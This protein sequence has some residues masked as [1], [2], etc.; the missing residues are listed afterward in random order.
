MMMRSRTVALDRRHPLLEAGMA[1]L[2]A[3]MLGAGTLGAQEKEKDRKG[4]EIPPAYRPPPG[5]CRVWIEDVPP[6]QQPAS[7]DCATALKN[8]PEKGRVIFGNDY[9][10]K[11]EKKDEK[12]AGPVKAFSGGGKGWEDVKKVL[13]VKKPD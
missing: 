10:S 1:I 5:M 11:K 4:D 13:K 3:L 6:A 8:K 9:V 2:A 7:T 12:P